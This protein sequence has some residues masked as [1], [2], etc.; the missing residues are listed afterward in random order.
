MG[1]KIWLE[2]K[3]SIYTDDGKGKTS[4]FCHCYGHSLNLAASD[5]VKKCKVMSD[6]LDTTFEIS[7]LIKYSPKRNAMFDKLKRELAPDC[8]GF[9][10]LCPTR[11]TVRGDSLKSV[12]DNYAV[13]QEEFNFCL[14]SRLEPDIKSRI[15]GIKHQ[16]STFEFF[17]GIVIG[18]RILK[19][20]DNLS[21]T[22]QHKDISA[23]EGQEVASLSVRTLEGMRDEKTFELFWIMVR[24]LVSEHDIGEPKLPRKRK[25]PRHLEIG[26]SESP[27]EYYKRIYYEALDL[28]VNCIKNRFDQPGYAMYKNLET[29]LVTA[30]NKKDYKDCFKIVTDF[31]GT[32]LSQS[33][34]KTQLKILATHFDNND[35]SSVSFRDIKSYFQNLTSSTCTLFSEVVTL[36]QLVLV[37][38]ATN[39]T[40]ERSFSAMRRVKNYLRS[41]M[42]QQ[43]FNHLM[44][45]HVHKAITDDLD[46]IQIANNFITKNEHREHVFG[47]FS[48]EDLM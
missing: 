17:F 23:I 47:K 31:Y 18:E 39:A 27:K 40:S 3:G 45:L 48:N 30:A 25:A 41:T 13:L 34:L 44:I 1:Q 4:T 24:Q 20:T 42:G 16:M 35:G 46:I 21:K 8:P 6:A 2:K 26:S 43:Q 28:A 5:A 38:P 22:L 15:I 14:E 32:D 9:R 12:I 11:W 33:R 10:V 37:L 7:K 36:M 29:L 19:H